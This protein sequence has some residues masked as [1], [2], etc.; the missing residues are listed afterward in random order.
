MPKSTL[1]QMLWLFFFNFLFIK[2]CYSPITGRMQLGLECS[3]KNRTF[4][5]GEL[6]VNDVVISDKRA[7]RSMLENSRQADAGEGGVA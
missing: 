6:S 7:Y 3:P 5:K 2:S 4:R 1:P